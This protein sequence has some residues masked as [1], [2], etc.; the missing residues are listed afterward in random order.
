MVMGTVEI[1][2][3]ADIISISYMVHNAKKGI[4]VFSGMGGSLLVVELD[5]PNWEGALGL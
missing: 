5:Q 3:K 1:E 2:N 4:W